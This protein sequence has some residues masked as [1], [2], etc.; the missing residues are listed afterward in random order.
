MSKFY[1]N[2]RRLA[3]TGAILI[4]VSALLGTRIER[5]M[6][7][8]NIME[9]IDKYGEVL[10]MV[11]HYYVDKVDVSELNDA[12]IVGLLGKLDPHSVYMPPKNVK[13]QDESFR[14]NFE[15]I[16]VS[17]MILKDTIT[18][19]S[20]VPGGPSE[21]LGIRAG[22][23]IVTIDGHSA[24]KLHEEDVRKELRGPKGTK[25]TV[26]IVRYGQP[27]PMNFTITR[28]VIPLVSVMA[29]FMVDPTTGYV[30]VGR[31][32]GT[33][34]AELLDALNDL[35][36]KGMQRVILD[37]RGNP[38]GYLEQ[39]VQVADEFIGGNKT[40]VY[41]KGRVSNFDDV[42]VSQPG[43]AFERTPLVV[44]V[45]NGSASASEIVSGALQ[46]LDRALIVGQTTFGKGLVQRQFPLKDGS[47]VRL[48]I[49]RYYTPS[50]RSI[51]RPYEGAHYM[52]STTYQDEDEDNYSHSYDVTTDTSRPKFK[53]AAGRT[54]YGGGGITPDFIV[55]NDTLQ[56]ATKRLRA[57]G[58][59][60]DYVEDYVTEHVGEIKAHDS[61]YFITNF[62][63]ESNWADKILAMAKEE[64]NG[65]PRAEVDMKEFNIDRAW[66]GTEL[67]AAIGGRI[68]GYNV[69]TIVL[70]P[71]DRQYQKAYNVLGEAGHL[72]QAFK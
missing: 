56:T 60:A 54:I 32:A 36:S 13:E 46:D 27:Q 24:L 61:A 3:M 8:D 21:Q 52:K 62:K 7:D 71:F 63:L 41:T 6:S 50:G 39:A 18:V 4:V 58:I 38:G 40:I 34:H 17:F 53:T 35:K 12:G 66:I 51:Q 67:K 30:D 14:G 20:P 70:L 72:A 19:D 5:A 16:G 10:N 47:A 29:H 49:S 28:D 48:T 44:L 11:Q 26:G 1:Y 57:A 37:L 64:K 59:L 65:K 22:D 55:R 42:Q 33:T 45:D 9:Q 25:V 31:F 23:K 15:G 43:Q 2:P 69:A 68:Y